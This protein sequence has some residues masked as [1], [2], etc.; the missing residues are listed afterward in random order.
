[1]TGVSNKSVIR[2][3]LEFYKTVNYKTGKGKA[4]DSGRVGKCAVG[5]GLEKRGGVVCGFYGL[6]HFFVREQFF[7]EDAAELAA[8]EL[9]ALLELAAQGGSQGATAYFPEFGGLYLP[10]VHL[11]GGTHGRDE[12]GACLTGTADEVGFVVEAVDG[13]DD[14]VVAVEPEVIGSLGGVEGMDGDDVGVGVDV[15]QA[16]AQHIG[17]D[18]SDGRSGGHELTVDVTGTDGVEID[19]REMADAGTDETF[20]TPAAYAADTEK[21]DTRA[22]ELVHV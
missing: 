18:L 4:E 16:V 15:E 7:A 5:A 21:D 10:G 14:D 6:L 11:E 12:E 20:G 13:V 1:M 8:G 2:R 17:L 9:T 22:G 19:H 3:V